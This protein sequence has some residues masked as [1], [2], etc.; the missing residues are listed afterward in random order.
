MYKVGPQHSWIAK[1]EYDSTH[2]FRAEWSRLAARQHHQGRSL[3]L[4]ILFTANQQ[5]RQSSLDVK[6]EHFTGMLGQIM[7]V[8]GEHVVIIITSTVFPNIPMSQ[9]RYLHTLVTV[10][11]Q[12][13]L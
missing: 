4:H 5:T 13:L 7:A 11:M 12:V 1:A 10:G 9:P 3:A 2:N 6:S 8:W